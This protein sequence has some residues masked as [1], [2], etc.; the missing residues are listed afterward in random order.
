MIVAI[1][2]R[3]LVIDPYRDVLAQERHI[4]GVADHTREELVEL[5]ELARRGAI[6]TSRVITRRV[7]LEASAINAVLDD[8]D[9]GT[10]HLRTVIQRF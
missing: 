2:L 6:D 5:L 10:N 4:I 9:Q 3:E 1:N 8:L 7:A